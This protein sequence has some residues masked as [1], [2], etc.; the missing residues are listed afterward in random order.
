[1]EIKVVMLGTAGSSPTK[2]RGMPAVALVYDG[3]VFLFDCGEAT[4]MQMLRYGINA[5]KLRAIFISHTHG[6]HIIGVAGLVRTLA[7]NR[8]KEP[9]AIFVPKGYESVVKSL[10]SFDKAMLGYRIDVKGVRSGEVYKGNGYSISAFELKH[11]IPTCGYIFRENEKRNFIVEKTK[12]LGIKGEMYS[13]LQKQ[14]KL[15]VGSKT[16]R[17]E[18]VTTVQHGKSVVYA[19]DTRPVAATVRAAKG[20]QLLIHESSYAYAERGMASERMHSTA[21]EV[22]QA[23]K[24]AGVKKL[25]LTHIS[26]RYSNQKVLEVEAQKAFKNSKVASD[27]EII[28]V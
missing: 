11:S 22:A 20:A 17:L 1:M 9:L 7:L 12:K 8:R 6:D 19:S 25:L 21:L 5:S 28:I 23:A 16:I 27:G 15:K 10:L 18:D 24:K 4:Q 13:A 26:A 14:G 3:N 2:T